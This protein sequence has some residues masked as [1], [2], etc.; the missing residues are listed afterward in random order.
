MRVSYD[1]DYRSSQLQPHV[2]YNL[3]IMWLLRLFIQTH[4]QYGCDECAVGAAVSLRPVQLVEYDG[5]VTVG[6][7]KTNTSHD[8]D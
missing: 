3:R 6:D 5:S 1:L 2:F 7:I 8:E 4:V